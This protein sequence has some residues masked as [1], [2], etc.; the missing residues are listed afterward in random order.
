MK[1][2]NAEQVAR[3][4]AVDFRSGQLE[5]DCFVIRGT[6]AQALIPACS[7]AQRNMIV[8]GNRHMRGLVWVLGRTANSV[9]RNAPCDGYIAHKVGGSAQIRAWRFGLMHSVF[10]VFYV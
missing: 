9:A 5:V 3:E 10:R 1:A 6:P 7:N 2:N 4:A 8:V